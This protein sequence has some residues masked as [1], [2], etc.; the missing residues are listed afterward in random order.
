MQGARLCSLL[1]AVR[2]HSLHHV[3][4][5]TD[6]SIATG[7]GYSISESFAKAGVAR[8]IIIQRRDSVLAAAKES[9]EKAY[10]NTKV[11]TYA[12][13]QSDFPRMTEI[14]QTVGEIDVLIS[15]AT[16]T[17]GYEG[18]TVFHPAREIKT[19]SVAGDYNVNVVG[20]FHL[21][22]TFLALPSTAS[23]GPK[24]VIHVSSNTSQ[25]HIPG[26][27]TYCSSKSAANQ[28][29]THFAF[30]EPEGNVKFYSYHPGTIATHLATTL[31]NLDG[32]VYEDGEFSNSP[33]LL[34]MGRC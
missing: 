32:L 18:G 28:I 8:I 3:I 7:I 11:E 13:S 24:S 27:S 12:A 33:G 10:P 25:L 5:I 17:S 26:L 15:C 20:L 16:N 23:S 14:L 6:I 22:S 2:P 21:V 19:E 31:V 29:I 9:L 34:G 1:L 4:L 30:D